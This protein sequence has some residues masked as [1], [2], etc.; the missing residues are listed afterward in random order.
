MDGWEWARPWLQIR[1][2]CDVPGDGLVYHG[3]HQRDDLRCFVL[4]P[5]EKL[6]VIR[7]CL[8]NNSW[9]YA[10][11]LGHIISKALSEFWLCI[12]HPI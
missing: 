12:T 3:T 4:K 11:I 5:Y 9:T 2:D 7:W 6:S 1:V 10:L 8:H